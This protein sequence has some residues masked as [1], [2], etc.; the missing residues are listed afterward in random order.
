MKFTRGGWSEIKPDLIVYCRV[1][2]ELTIEQ[3]C[4]SRG[5]CVIIRNTFKEDVLNELH[6]A[7]ADMVRKDP[8]QDRMCGG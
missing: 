3:G 7:H 1:R 6:T 5:V 8:W 2:D 4:L